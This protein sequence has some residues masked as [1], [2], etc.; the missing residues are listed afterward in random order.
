M[1]GTTFDVD[2]EKDFLSVS[3]HQVLL[4]KDGKEQTV[5][6]NQIFS[7]STFS[8]IELSKYI[9]ELR[10]TAW[11]QLNTEYDQA[12]FQD[13][14]QKLQEKAQSNNPL[15]F[16]MEVFGPKWRFLYEL[17][18]VNSPQKLEELF[19][20]LSSEQKQELLP[21]I[22]TA[23]QKFN[24]VKPDDTQNYEKKI[25]YKKFLLELSNTS[26]KES[27]LQYSLYDLQDAL[28]GKSK[29]SLQSTLSLL[30]EHSDI[31]K[32]LNFDFLKDSFNVIPDGLEEAMKK[33]FQNVKGFI[34]GGIPQVPDI[35]SGKETL[36]AA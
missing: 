22:Q 34:Q 11:T 4:K 15:L 31:V 25:V 21:K 29:D 13:L 30:S 27:L 2:L 7:F 6:E 26:E 5:S 14:Q 33:E 20:L 19:A 32:T 24:F 3:D 23:Y 12:Y 17:D 9:S 10:D 16:L 36:D 35:S 28:T 8:F 1:R 18:T